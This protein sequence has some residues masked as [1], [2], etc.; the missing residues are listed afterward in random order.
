M[1][2][3]W[4]D[5]CLKARIAG[6]N[7]PRPPNGGPSWCY[8][9]TIQ[10][11]LSSRDNQNPVHDGIGGQHAHGAVVELPDEV[12]DALI[13]LKCAFP[14]DGSSLIAAQQAAKEQRER[15]RLAQERAA[16]VSRMRLHD[17]LP[18]EV[19]ALVHEHGDE[20]TEAYLAHQQELDEQPTP[21]QIELK[22][23]RGGRPRKH[24]RPT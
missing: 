7:F 1:G 9:K 10:I 14:V 16:A 22:R 19:R 13:G 2:R 24:P 3:F 6:R 20:A 15:Q 17:E 18:P 12:A 21:E 11:D 5:R 4:R 23:R 8:V